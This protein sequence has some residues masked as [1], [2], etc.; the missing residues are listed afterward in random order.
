MRSLQESLT[1]YDITD[2]IK[3]TKSGACGGVGLLIEKL[4]SYPIVLHLL[5]Y[6]L[7]QT[8]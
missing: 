3:H 6:S 2:L 7:T 5:H 8:S 1:Y 4:E